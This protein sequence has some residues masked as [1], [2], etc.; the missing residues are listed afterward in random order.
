MSNLSSQSFTR[1]ELF[2]D[3]FGSRRPDDKLN[4]NEYISHNQS[5]RNNQY[6]SLDPSKQN[7]IH[8]QQQINPLDS[9][10]IDQNNQPSEADNIQ[11]RK[12]VLES[13]QPIQ[14]QQQTRPLQ[15]QQ[16]QNVNIDNPNDNI[17]LRQY[18]SS[19]T[20]GK[21]HKDQQPDQLYSSRPQQPPLNQQQQ[22]QPLPPRFNSLTSKVPLPPP[23]LQNINPPHHQGQLDP[24]FV[25]Q[26]YQQQHQD[27]YKQQP[28]HIP[29]N[30]LNFSEG[31]PQN[32]IYE[33]QKPYSNQSLK[34]KRSFS[35]HPHPPNRNQPLPIQQ[36]IQQ[37]P[38]NNLYPP[39]QNL[40]NI[41]PIP[42]PRRNHFNDPKT[43]LNSISTDLGS[44]QNNLKKG[45]SSNKQISPILKQGINFI[46]RNSRTSTSPV[47]PQITTFN[48]STK[49]QGSTPLRSPS[50]PNLR[51]SPGRSMSLNSSSASFNGFDQSSKHHSKESFKKTSSGRIIPQK[52]EINSGSIGLGM[53]SRS[54]ASISQARRASSSA[55]LSSQRV[56][57]FSSL[58]SRTI[59]TT[60]SKQPKI[61]P[62][63]L[64]RV[65]SSFKK[66]I[67]T[68]QH[69][70]DGLEYR[71]SFTGSEAV[72]AISYIIRTTDR[73]LAL[74]LGRALDAQKFFHDVT[75]E[76]RL[77]DSNQEIYQFDEV[78]LQ[79]ENSLARNGSF[80]S[81]M[82]LTPSETSTPQLPIPAA[83]VSGQSIQL[84]PH[85]VNGVFTLLTECYSPTCTRDSLCYSIAC[86]RRLEQQARLNMKPQGGLKRD[87][88]HA[89]LHEEEEKKQLWSHTVPK[90]L[91][92]SLDKKEI[93][94]Q[95]LIY[96]VV[97]TERTF[98]KNLEYIRDFWIIPLRESNI[99][100]ITEREKFIR[101]VFFNVID[102][103][104]IATRFRDTLIR[105]QQLRPVVENVGDIFL[106]FIPFFEP[107]I[108]YNA[109]QCFAKYE[110]ERQKAA[111]PIFKRFIEETERLSESNRLNI[112]SYLSQATTRTVRYN[113]LL[114]DI[115][116]TT[117]EDSIDLPDLNR[118]S[119]SILKLLER[120][121]IKVGKAE[122]RHALILL[123]Q[124]LVFRPGEY[125]DLKLGAENRKILYT[126]PLKKR[127]QDKDNQGDIQVYLLDHV[128]L[129]VRVK[130]INKREQH[131]VYQRP[132]PL[133]LLF[134]STAEELPSLRPFM[135]KA[136][137]Y[138]HV[139]TNTSSSLGLGSPTLSS[140]SMN[141]MVDPTKNP[142]SFG[143]VGRRGYELTLY[144]VTNSAQE[145]LISVIDQQQRKLRDSNDIFTLKP[146][147]EKL[148]DI[149]NKINCLAPFDG[150]RKLLFGT[151]SGV[152]IS[153]VKLITNGN[154]KT[155][156]KVSKPIK[157]ISKVNVTQLEVLEEYQT[158][159][160]LA[161]KK[162]Y[163][164]PIDLIKTNIDKK[165]T[166]IS[167]T[168]SKEIMSHVLFFK[169]GVC[170]GR[171]LVCAA[172]ND[173]IRVFE[174]TDP[175]SKKMSKKKFKNETK[176]F[177]F[178]SEPV[179]ISFLKTRLIVGC[180]K[181]FE[182][183]SLSDGKIESILDPADTSLDFI[184]N[185]EGLKPLGIHRISSNFLLSYS[186]FSFFINKNGWRTRPDWMIN[187]EGI[188]QNFTLW[189][190]YL[191]AFEPN[192][193]EIRNVQNGE[194][195]RV[196]LGENIRLLHTGSQEI[197][198][199]YEDERGY[200][201]VASLDFWDKTNNTNSTINSINK[202][203]NNNN[204]NNNNNDDDRN[205]LRDIKEV[206]EKKL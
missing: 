167:N 96:E 191:L 85:T 202:S 108:S 105:R 175:F 28:S 172:K 41:P 21:I 179:S 111:N 127:N 89:S 173:L 53:K 134:A 92:E 166:S 18:N 159:L 109:G 131:K 155:V 150:G 54:M 199:A 142:I 70:K 17:K 194:L 112:S 178:N 4:S 163:A 60:S 6:N 158:L 79:N 189:Y 99:I 144:G 168:I 125:V 45:S 200:D 65:A 3:I 184:T 153:E 181:G 152:F 139:L 50:N 95:E 91:L 141:T 58:T 165:S 170:G 185:R 138:A 90:Q 7:K 88:S 149:S 151:D 146:L 118:A 177:H 103:L 180:T 71:D 63:L 206:D 35:D 12:P 84:P 11:I 69:N 156:R 33:Q 15:Q 86:P 25:R 140:T 126:A 116:K 102:I 57:S 74:L 36:S 187:W 61:Y 143:Y 47:L 123:K 49:L 64:S 135:R 23:Q 68:A 119:G 80:S 124:R 72:D 121:N 114:K 160:A 117:K 40:N 13:N 201:V 104:N 128:L 67:I 101:T 148:F 77:R 46:T 24:S 14:Q 182:I 98:V 73:N 19:Q 205:K 157:I 56:S 107:F 48:S 188:P 192:F 94:R 196:I 43:K 44:S 129:F 197:L 37:Q 20:F 164:W 2:N 66:I 30:H 81:D 55:S 97:A 10:P 183:V 42:E 93:K 5:V 38:L 113:L 115:I 171:M 136:G 133:P 39:Q 82:T 176:E 186:D 154:D 147:V 106:E 137:S 62:A 190:P 132:I 83:L 120:I 22:Q 203:D 162:L 27:S 122:D 87:Q 26:Q 31:V 204:N 169:V 51:T 195:L 8:N 145:S 1:D 78:Y 193:I 130:V 52:L 161:D 174:P 16:Q 100:P 198:Y 76:H 59:V 29:Q 34:N 32:Q 75:Y 9:I 110:L